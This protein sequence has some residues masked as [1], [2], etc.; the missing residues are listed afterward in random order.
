MDE[1]TVYRLAGEE[2]RGLA[3]GSDSGKK[4]HRK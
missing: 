4:K 1:W 2:L 3:E